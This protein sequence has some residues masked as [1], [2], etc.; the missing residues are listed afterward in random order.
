MIL[1]LIQISQNVDVD[2][3]EPHAGLIVSISNDNPALV[4]CVDDERLEFQDDDLVVFSEVHGMA[5]LN[6]GKLR[7]IKS[8]R[9]Y[10]LYLEEN[11]TNF[12]SYVKGC[13]VTQVKQPKNIGQAKS[14]VVA[15]AT[16]LINPRLQIQKAL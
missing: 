8:C 6:D 16:A 4:T 7:K 9:L 15:S 2:G 13:I 5:E 14:T 3:E 12:G 10:S 11:T 1:K